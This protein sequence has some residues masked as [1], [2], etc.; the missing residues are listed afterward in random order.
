MGGQ[1]WI[2]GDVPGDFHLGRCRG[3]A[4]ACRFVVGIEPVVTAR[5]EGVRHGGIACRID[6]RVNVGELVEAVPDNDEMY[7]LLVNDLERVDHFS[8]RT[9][10][11]QLERGRLPGDGL[12]R[13]GLDHQR[14]HAP[15]LAVGRMGVV[16]RLSFGV[17]FIGFG[18]T[19]AQE[20]EHCQWHDQLHGKSPSFVLVERTELA[21][22]KPVNSITPHRH[23]L[24]ARPAPVPTPALLSRSCSKTPVE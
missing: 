14:G 21:T 19:P 4:L 8:V 12:G 9:V 15:P 18:R 17:V 1:D 24:E 22:A 13:I 16:T 10:D 3:L 7:F 5:G 20:E 2:C 6:L 11:H 23:F